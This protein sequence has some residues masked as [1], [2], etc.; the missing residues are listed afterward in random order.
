[1]CQQICVV[2]G[3]PPPRG[4]Y[5]AHSGLFRKCIPVAFFIFFFTLQSLLCLLQHSTYTSS[6]AAEV[7]DASLLPRVVFLPSEESL[8]PGDETSSLD[9]GSALT[10]R[11]R[12]PIYLRGSPEVFASN[13]SF[14]KVRPMLDDPSKVG[15]KR[16]PSVTRKLADRILYALASIYAFTDSPSTADLTKQMETLYAQDSASPET[17][18]ER[19][20][21]LGSR[22]STHCAFQ[23]DGESPTTRTFIIIKEL[24][25]PLDPGVAPESQTYQSQQA[26]YE[27]KLTLNITWDGLLSGN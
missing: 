9:Q 22:Y 12:T 24:D 23:T 25:E 5:T 14:T 19:T 20:D 21:P 10:L 8:P 18:F 16:A 17:A 7:A 11:K 4:I 26:I 6:D 27:P 2:I 1:M 13:V 15:M 3:R